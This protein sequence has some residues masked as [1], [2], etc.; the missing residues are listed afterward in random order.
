VTEKVAH[1]YMDEVFRKGAKDTDVLVLG[2]THYPLLRPLLRRVVPKHVEIVDSAEAT[3]EAVARQ[4]NAQPR[5]VVPHSILTF[6][7]TDSVERFRK[8]GELFMEQK[9]E[10][11]QHVDIEP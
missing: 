11:V 2:C 7:A 10:N 6:F 3:A 4:L 8:L 9:L 1:I 5:T